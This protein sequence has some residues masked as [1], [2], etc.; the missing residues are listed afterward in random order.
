MG[1]D[2]TPSGRTMRMVPMPS[3]TRKLPSGRNTSDHAPPILAVMVS[4]VNA[5]EG[6]VGAGAVVWPGKAGLGWGVSA[7]TAGIRD[8]AR[9]TVVS[10]IDSCAWY[11]E[12]R[13]SSTEC[14]LL[15]DEPC[16]THHR[17]RIDP[18][19]WT[20]AGDIA[21][22]A[23]GRT[24]VRDGLLQACRVRAVLC[25]APV[26]GIA[27]VGVPRGSEL[28]DWMFSSG[29]SAVGVHGWIFAVERRDLPASDRNSAARGADF[30][31]SLDSR[32]LPASTASAK[33][34]RLSSS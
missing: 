1:A 26:G 32:F 14:I 20:G 10:F 22:G 16:S 33:L 34:H 9:I 15:T 7:R 5:G 3:V 24:A 21:A 12:W 17:A 4:T 28:S 27:R 19:V 25:F 23:S 31:H 2:T 30:R 6:F 29:G 18:V 11:R 8:A 13:V